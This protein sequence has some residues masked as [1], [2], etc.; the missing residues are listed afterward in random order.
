MPYSTAHM[1]YIVP[2]IIIILYIKSNII[3]NRDKCS[4]SIMHNIKIQLIISLHL[5]GIAMHNRHTA[6]HCSSPHELRAYLH[7]L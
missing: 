2:S 1:Q 6:L 3:L 5:L 4:I 7:L